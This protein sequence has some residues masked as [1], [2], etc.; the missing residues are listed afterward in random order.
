MGLVLAAD[1][2]DLCLQLQTISRTPSAKQSFLSGSARNKNSLVA[3]VME[4][5]LKVRYRDEIQVPIVISYGGPG[6]PQVVSAWMS[7]W[8]DSGQWIN[9][10]LSDGLNS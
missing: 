9:M 4:F 8:S 1:S 6:M 7:K 3:R 2:A 5:K 10:R